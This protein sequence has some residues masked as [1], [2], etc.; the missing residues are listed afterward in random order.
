MQIEFG[1][2]GFNL[3]DKSDREGQVL[4][5]WNKRNQNLTNLNSIKSFET[6][7]DEMEK[8]LYDQITIGFD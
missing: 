1:M 2:K 4:T 6:N 3:I 7:V 8:N 5:V